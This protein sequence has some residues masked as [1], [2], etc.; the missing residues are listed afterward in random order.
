MPGSVMESPDCGRKRFY[1]V[2]HNILAHALQGIGYEYIFHIIY[3]LSIIVI[4]TVNT[5]LSS[6][7]MSP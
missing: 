7:F 1:F 4:I 3:L 5:L 6:L 2:G